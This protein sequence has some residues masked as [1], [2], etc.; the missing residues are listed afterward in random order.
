MAFSWIHYMIKPLT[1]LRFI[2][3]FMVFMSHNILFEKDKNPFLH[4]LFYEGCVGVSF[5]FILSGFILSYVYQKDINGSNIGRRAFYVSRLARIYPLHIITM[6]IWVYMRKDHPLNEPYITNFISNIFLVQ[7]FY[8]TNEIR[9]NT[10]AW[11]LSD[12]MFFYLLFPVL[13][14]WFAS[15]RSKFI[16]MFTLASILLLILCPIFSGTRYE[17]WFL[18]SFPP[19]RL[20]DFILGII[21]YNICQ[22]V[23]IQNAIG[24]NSPTL[25]EIFV[26]TLFLIFYILAFFI[27]EVYRYSIWYWLPV[28]L[29]ISV[30]YFQAGAVSKFLSNDIFVWLGEISFGVYMFHAIVLWYIRRAFFLL[31]IDVDRP[32]IFVIG[33]GLTILISGFSL[34]YIEAPLSKWIKQRFGNTRL[35]TGI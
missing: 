12:E 14:A 2:F 32:I 26:I 35:M 31:N 7:S 33:I 29:L 18:Y 22:S 10:A 11:S 3:A 30:F 15:I 17:E 20:L 8:P 9:F 23:K 27:P 4:H 24:E 6:F 25:M 16:A 21:L 5:F 28:G 34:K 1:S 13:I 19:V